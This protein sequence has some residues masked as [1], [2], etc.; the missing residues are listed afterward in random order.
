[1]GGYTKELRGYF[2]EEEHAEIMEWLERQKKFARPSHFVRFAIYSAM[3]KSR[4]GAHHALS[5]RPVGRPPV[6]RGAVVRPEI[7]GDFAIEVAR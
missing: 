3:K 7:Q 5:G 2:T 1:M 4:P 6:N